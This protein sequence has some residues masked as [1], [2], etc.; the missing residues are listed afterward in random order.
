MG[1]PDAWRG[2]GFQGDRCQAAAGEGQ[3]RGNR[4]N[5]QGE[6][7]CLLPAYSADS[8]WKLSLK[9]RFDKGSTGKAWS[10][11]FGLPGTVEGR[12]LPFPLPTLCQ[13]LHLL[14]GNRMAPPRVVRCSIC[15]FMSGATSKLCLSFSPRIS[16]FRPPGM[17]K[18]PIITAFPW[19]LR[20]VQESLSKCTQDKKKG[21]RNAT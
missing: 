12:G 13:G 8:N 21:L 10:R 2:R 19:R 3:G 15:T 5:G 6:E 1:H 18:L 7:C 11:V 4:M 17:P 20:G 16:V 14:Q 9:I